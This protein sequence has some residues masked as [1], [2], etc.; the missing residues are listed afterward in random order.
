MP[1]SI[2]T[3]ALPY[4]NGSIHLGHMV[5]HVMCDVFARAR[6]LRGHETIFICAEDTHGTP[7]EMSALREGI[8]PEALVARSHEEHAR[9]FAGFNIRYDNY[10]TTNSD[11]NR[12]L[13]HFI[14]TRLRDAGHVTRKASQQ[15]YS[16]PLGRF[17]NDR[18]IKGT[19]PRCG[20]EDQYGDVCEKCGAT[21]EPTEL[22]D[23]RDA[24]TG[25]TPVMRETEH[26]Y[27][28][29]SAFTD[30][31]REWMAEGVPQEAVRNFMHTWLEGGLEDWCISR[32]APY[33]GFEIPDAPG[34]YFYVWLDAPIGYIAS[35]RH[36][37]E[38]RGEDW[39]TWWGEDADTEIVHVI[40]K[41]IVY[42]HTLFWPAM[43]RTAGLRLPSRVHVHGMLTVDG[44]KMSKSRGTFIRASTWLRH[45]DADY[46][47]F[48][49]A[50]KLGDGV[51]DIDLSFEDFVARVNADLINNVVNLCSRVTKFLASRFEGRVAAFD[52]AEVP[53]CGSLAAGL[54]E[55]REAYER[56]D[57]RGAMRRVAALGGEANLFFQ[58]AAPWASIREDAERA[59]R[60]CS[61]AL[62]AATA[63]MTALAPVV[64]AL[65]GRYAAA[66]G[67]EELSWAMAE[68]TWQPPQVTGPETLLERLDP[69]R[70]KAL[71]EDA[72]EE[73]MTTE[74]KQDGA[75]ESTSAGG[76]GTAPA[77]A[78][79]DRGAGLA[80][81]GEEIAFDDF[82]K[83]DLR[84]GV[85]KE[86][87]FVEGANKLL[88]L[89]VDIGHRD[90]NVFAG[91]R[92]AYP[93]PEVLVGRRVVVVA[94]LAPR[95]MR[96][97][98]S[99]GMLLATS[100]EDGAG[101]QLVHPDA[102]AK[103]G[104]TVR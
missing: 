29:L 85:V 9:D 21:Y 103:A 27:V 23:P 53:L 63:L 101:L 14:Y 74:E 64:P 95:K 39:R 31:L 67:V 72:R 1:R 37:A 59:H 15:M 58:E 26:L 43:L 10:Y 24:I 83:V 97:G 12:E 81:L 25:A 19:C 69:K 93:E 80:K 51:E 82:A 8:T 76:E 46:L 2:I 52:P 4:A 40:G 102:A 5:E 60:D 42:F 89:T 45:L 87:G 79:A 56:F 75:V 84:I 50:A 78:E 18:L 32:D 48:Y 71:L 65:A 7:I 16:E 73:L 92:K 38:Q 99:E 66:L 61:I 30:F 70:V 55:V 91:V 96:F 20:A 41:D 47:R 44:K 94:N 3:A 68:P 28:G 77:E 86:A 34:K 35:T 104:W 90:I 13:A 98:V 33:F 100:A 22:I 54:E 49:Y 88:Q 17:L 57:L 62:H 11:E 6:R 36:W